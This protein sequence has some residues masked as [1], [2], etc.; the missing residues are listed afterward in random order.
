MTPEGFEPPTV[1]RKGLMSLVIAPILRSVRPKKNISTILKWEGIAIDP[2]GALVAVP[3]MF[4]TVR[5]KYFLSPFRVN[6]DF[7]F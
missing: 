3:L 6:R 2:I 7:K 5:I 1:M 4:Y